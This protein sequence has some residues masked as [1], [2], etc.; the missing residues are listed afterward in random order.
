MGAINHESLCPS[1]HKAPRS[2][3]SYSTGNLKLVIARSMLSVPFGW[4]ATPPLDSDLSR[5][6]TSKSVM[7]DSYRSEMVNSFVLRLS[8]VFDSRKSET[9]QKLQYAALYK[10]D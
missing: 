10:R 2:L 4:Y 7:A 1:K 8:I 6:S 5:E 9:M 3:P